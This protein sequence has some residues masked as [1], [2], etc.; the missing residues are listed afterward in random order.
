MGPSRKTRLRTASPIA[1]R[2]TAPGA[3]PASPSMN[4][5]AAFAS[6]MIAAT[7]VLKWNPS[8]SRVTLRTV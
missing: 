1:A 2:S 4:D 7:A 5:L 3:R 8:R 6:S